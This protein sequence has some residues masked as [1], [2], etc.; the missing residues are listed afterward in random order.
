MTTFAFT[1][2]SLLILQAKHVPYK[3]IVL[4]TSEG[5]QPHIAADMDALRLAAGCAGV[6]RL[7]LTAEHDGEQVR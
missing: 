7:R 4:H 6:Y 3:I 5:P 2:T 1:K